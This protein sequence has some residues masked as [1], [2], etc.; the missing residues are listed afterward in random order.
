MSVGPE[1]EVVMKAMHFVDDNGNPL[2]SANFTYFVDIGKRFDVDSNENS[3]LFVPT[4]AEKYTATNVYYLAWNKFDEKI[5]RQKLIF[6]SD[7]KQKLITNW[8]ER[9]SPAHEPR[10][11]VSEKY[12]REVLEG[13]QMS[14]YQEQNHLRIP[15]RYLDV[16]QTF[17][18]S[19]S[20]FLRGAGFYYGIDYCDNKSERHIKN[21]T[22][23]LKEY[24]EER[25][26]LDRYEDDYIASLLIPTLCESV[27][28]LG[29]SDLVI[30]RAKVKVGKLFALLN[31]VVLIRLNCTKDNYRFDNIVYTIDMIVV[32]E[33]FAQAELNRFNQFYRKSF[34]SEKRLNKDKLTAIAAK[35]DEQKMAE[36]ESIFLKAHSMKKKWRMEGEN[37]ITNYH[38]S[39]NNVEDAA[40]YRIDS[41]GDTPVL[42]N[43]SKA[44]VSEGNIELRRVAARVAQQGLDEHRG[45]IEAA[46]TT[47]LKLAMT[48]YA[49]NGTDNLEEFDRWYEKQSNNSLNQ[50]IS[51]LVGIGVISNEYTDF[52]FSSRKTID[53]VSTSV[54]L[55]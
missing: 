16:A 46:E 6:L 15:N 13:F 22:K 21:M 8:E 38:P 33:E 18:A 35:E 36:L 24:I 54:K 25:I 11:N 23:N 44:S 29:T 30:G 12:I 7:Y 51:Y 26:N 52:E 3:D 40:K 2:H 50:K 43:N 47:E 28:L 27:F 32:T 34:P 1:D 17:I 9:G 14:R 42:N 31:D 5:Y 53:G 45:M 4:D 19:F 55:E 37:I 49:S 48:I 10:P 39:T 41:S 20:S